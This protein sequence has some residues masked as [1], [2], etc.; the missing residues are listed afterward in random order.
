MQGKKKK[1]REDALWE[2]SNQAMW[3]EK[4]EVKK[5]SERRD[6]VLDK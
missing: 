5:G 3:E 2:M 6:R 4:K 1:K